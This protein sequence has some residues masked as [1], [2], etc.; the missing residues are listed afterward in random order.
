MCVLSCFSHIWLFATLWL[1]ASQA[2]LSMGFSRQEYWS[3]L[4]HPPPGDLPEP[5]IEPL[6]LLYWQAGSLSLAQPRK[7]I[8]I[9]I[10]VH[11]H[12]RI[13][14]NVHQ[15]FG[16]SKVLFLKSPR[17]LLMRAWNNAYLLGFWE[18][19]VYFKCIKPGSTTIATWSW[20]SRLTTFLFVC[21]CKL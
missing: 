3:G 5:G 12:F 16:N 7:P 11:I 21:F 10:Y 8:H 19:Q 18:I 13:K 4:T 6:C 17:S 1:V 9:Y 20:T 15:T 2:P 14:Q